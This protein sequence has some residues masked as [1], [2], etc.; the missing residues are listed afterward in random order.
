RKR[1]RIRTSRTSS[2]AR[3]TSV[4][5]AAVSRSALQRHRVEA[6]TERPNGR[7]SGVWLFFLAILGHGSCGAVKGR[8]FG[9]LLV[10][11]HYKFPRQGRRPMQ[12]T[13]SFVELP[14]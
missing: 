6:R 14:Q 7:L 5:A 12:L 1:S 11:R 13:S 2:F 9:N 10:I 8:V 4:I 3:A